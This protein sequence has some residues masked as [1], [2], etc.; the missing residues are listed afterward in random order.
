MWPC[1][2]DVFI[3]TKSEQKKRFSVSVGHMYSFLTQNMYSW[4]ELL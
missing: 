3:R 2:L 4:L 1:V